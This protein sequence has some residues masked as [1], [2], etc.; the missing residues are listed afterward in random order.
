MEP[1]ED[2]P[3]D[4]IG[5]AQ[6]GLEWEDPA[7]ATLLGVDRQQLR[8]A[9][10]GELERGLLLQLAEALKLS[11][12]ALLA[13]MDGLQPP[14]TELP[15]C[16]HIITSNWGDMRVNAWL[17]IA[18]DGK[19]SL[20]FD[21]GAEINPLQS[22]LE[23]LSVSIRQLILTHTHGDHIA[24]LDTLREKFPSMT[25]KTPAKEPLAGAAAVNDKD[26]IH[27]GGWR[28]E[29]IATPGHS[30]G[31]TSYAIYA[32]TNGGAEPIAV[33]VGDAL[34]AG[35]IGGIRLSAPELSL[36]ETYE[37]ALQTI[38]TRLLSFSDSTLLLP[39]HGP[40]TTVGWEKAHNPFLA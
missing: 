39:G 16:L 9:R 2:N 23:R 24:L 6:R 37:N 26:V 1:F 30:I 36:R 28:I 32:E 10:R 29:A 22:I 12:T 31:G 19:G 21:T 3:E 35:S 20:L 38:R 14:V 25:I 18:R 5:K 4:I 27:W 13:R 33:V 34:F 17:L 15:D 40:A 7:L 11:S 8:A